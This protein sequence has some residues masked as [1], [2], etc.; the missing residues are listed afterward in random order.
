MATKTVKDVGMELAKKYSFRTRRYI[1]SQIHTE[2]CL[3]DQGK[4]VME[5][6]LSSMKIVTTKGKSKRQHVSVAYEERMEDENEGSKDSDSGTT[7][8]GNKKPRWEPKNW[9]KVITNIREMRKQRD[10]PVDTM[11]CDKCSD[12]S[13]PPEVNV[14]D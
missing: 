12:K 3:D 9:P 7:E 6:K 5:N 2:D 4:P 14:A 8:N 1:S 10:A 11:G 13:A